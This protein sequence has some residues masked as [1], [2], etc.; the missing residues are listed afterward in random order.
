MPSK[1]S[2]LINAML[3]DFTSALTEKFP[4]QIDFILLFGSA[5][6]GEFRAGISDVDLLIQVKDEH[7][8]PAVGK[9][10]EKIF[11][12]L[13]RKHETRLRE[14][15]STKRAD[16]FSIFEKR[17]KLYK[18]FEVI[19]PKDIDW[20]NGR[21]SM[22]RLGAF[23]LVAPVS[24]F[25]KKVRKEGKILYGRNILKEM[26][27]RE[28]VFDTVKSLAVPYA[29]SLFAWLLALPFPDRALKYSI[30][31]V[32]YGI[33]NQLA[34]TGEE[35]SGKAHLNLLI[36]RFE[37]GE[38]YSVR[39]AQEAFYAKNNFGKISKEWSYLDKV[40]FCAQAPVYIAHNNLMSVLGR[41]V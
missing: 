6:R 20:K 31:A 22:K 10:A 32:L 8:V 4:S 33:D 11:W 41:R 35:Y 40:S 25:A 9:H 16:I 15:C 7:D 36:L 37:L 14:V 13:D 17:V 12:K 39:L 26:K 2:A 30:K 19:G 34:V 1:D 29:L 28:S 21:L 27:I 5:A 24:Q 38:Y 23:A 3:S 18:P